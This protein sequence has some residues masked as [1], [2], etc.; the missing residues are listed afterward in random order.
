MPKKSVRT[1][2][3]TAVQSRPNPVVPTPALMIEK[4]IVHLLLSLIK[5]HYFSCLD[6]RF[7]RR[8]REILSLFAC[9]QKKVLAGHPLKVGCGKNCGICCNHWPE[10]TYSFEVQYIADYLKKKRSSDIAGII[11]TLRGDVECLDHIKKTVALRISDVKE[12]AALGDIDPYDVALSSFYQMNRPCPLLDKNGS[13]SIYALRPLTCR[14]YVSFSQ[15]ALCRPGRILGDKAM[16][17]LL[18]LE[19]DTSELFDRLHF[20]YDVYDGD[21]SLRSMLY[22]ALTR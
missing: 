16:T 17:Y 3:K 14:V 1:S 12:R 21:T 13:C 6:K 18:D 9:Y 2:A 20:L 4:Q 8:Y 11:K 7:I 15:P 22:K 10:D 5:H 19:K